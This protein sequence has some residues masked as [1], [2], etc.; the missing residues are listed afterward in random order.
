MRRE[1]YYFLF[2]TGQAYAEV[3]RPNLAQNQAAST[4]KVETKPEQTFKK[5]YRNITH[6]KSCYK[7]IYMSPFGRGI[8]GKDSHFV[9]YPVPRMAF[10]PELTVLSALHCIALHPVL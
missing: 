3:N 1:I 8:I 4:L 5:C 10:Y 9:F 2:L 6:E 7:L